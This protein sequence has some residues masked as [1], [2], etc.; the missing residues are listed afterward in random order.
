MKISKSLAIATDTETSAVTLTF[1]DENGTEQTI[2]VPP[3]AADL[4]LLGLLATPP[5]HRSDG[6]TSQQRKPLVALGAQS[7]RFENGLVGLSLRVADNA[8]MQIAFPLEAIPDLQGH[9]SRLLSG[10]QPHDVH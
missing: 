7:L 6:K 4:L 3:K 9:L 10:E 1:V 5:S 8:Y 2:H